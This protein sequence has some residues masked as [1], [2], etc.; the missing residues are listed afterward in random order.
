MENTL[1]KTSINRGQLEQDLL[2]I[3]AKA[4]STAYAD[5]MAKIIFTAFQVAIL[6]SGCIKANQP[7]FVNNLLTYSEI[8]EYA[9]SKFCTNYVK[10]ELQREI[11]AYCMHVFSVDKEEV[12]VCFETG[13]VLINLLDF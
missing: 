10:Y 4:G 12:N 11:Q 5:I 2:D 8:C 9:Y 13:T 3:N 6:K 1:F 7:V